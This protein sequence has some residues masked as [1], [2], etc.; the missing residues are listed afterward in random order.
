MGQV[1]LGCCAVDRMIDGISERA[2]ESIGAECDAHDPVVSTD[3]AD[4]GGR[5]VGQRGRDE[6]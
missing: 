3:A 6:G 1:K 2:A 4:L 5:F